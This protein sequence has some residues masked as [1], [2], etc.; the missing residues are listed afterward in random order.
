VFM[1]FAFVILSCQDSEKNHEF[2]TELISITR[3]VD[4][5]FLENDSIRSV[6]KTLIVNEGTPEIKTIEDYNIYEDLKMLK[7]FDVATPRWADF[8]EI[9]K[10]DGAGLEKVEYTTEN[11]KA[12]ASH[13]IFF[14]N[15]DTIQSVKIKSR[16][17]TMISKQNTDIDWTP[18]E[19]YILR[20]HSKLLFQKP[21]TF[22]MEVR[23]GNVK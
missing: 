15:N 2:D 4:S 18:G 19:G 17:G 3:F 22:Q 9:K 1:G 23:Y 7:E 11:K 21:R 14:R 6:T 8:F 5:F 16:K 13:L 20:N 12:P 10:T